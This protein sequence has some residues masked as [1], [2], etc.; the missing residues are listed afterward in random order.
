MLAELKEIYPKGWR[1]KIVRIV[2]Q[3]KS[4]LKC[5]SKIKTFLECKMAMT[6]CDP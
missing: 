6:V 3:I 5:E 4:P 1:N 2:V